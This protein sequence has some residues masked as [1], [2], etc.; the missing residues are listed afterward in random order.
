MFWLMWKYY[1]L[2]LS[3][4]KDKLQ[5]NP[6][7]VPIHSMCITI[8]PIICVRSDHMN[9]AHIVRGAIQMA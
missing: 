8:T 6:C 4:S 2:N 1:A 9:I 7:K 5:S 3:T